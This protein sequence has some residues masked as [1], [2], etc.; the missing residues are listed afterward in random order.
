MKK[1]FWSAFAMSLIS[2]TSL[3]YS[4]T[5]AVD[6]FLGLESEIMPEIV[7][8]QNFTTPE[9]HD[10]GKWKVV[11]DKVAVD[12]P[13]PIKGQTHSLIPWSTLD[14]EDWLSLDT[15]LSEQ[16]F[17]KKT[18]NWKIRLRQ[19]N[20]Q[21]LT[22]K[23]LQCKGTCSVFRGSNEASVQHLSQIVEGDEIR[24][25]KDSVA[26]VYLMD[27]S[28]MRISPESSV[29]INEFN[30]SKNEFFILARLN[31]GHIFWHPRHKSEVVPVMEPE[32]DS[33]SLPLMVREAN[34]EYFER[35]IYKSQDD[36]LHLN[37]VMKFDETAISNQFKAINKLWNQ[38]NEI[39]TSVT[40]F[41]MVSP[42]STLVSKG[43]SFDY[44]YI[45]GG[46]GYFNKRSDDSSGELSLYLRGYTNP[47][48]ISISKTNWH[49]VDPSG[50]TYSSM[51]DAP[52]ILQI[53]DLLTKRIKTLE[54][55][56]EIWVEKFTLPLIQATKDPEK[57]ARDYGYTFW[58]EEI[59]Q[60]YNFLVE[61]TR[62]VETTNLRSLEN[63]LTR[64]ENN[65][66]FVNRDLTDDHYS[67]SLN[68]YLLGLKS[69][70]DKKKMRVKEMN[71][72]QYYVWIL[73][74]GKW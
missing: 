65:G 35:Q 33:V 15:W 44:L 47:E 13:K 7:G 25:L 58:G 2:I 22:G 27:G 66:E 30:M 19:A 32:T 59:E 67:A 43:V 56:R 31:K 3:G 51:D 12:L 6:D 53:T 57:L 55:A 52:G 16:K 28:L 20:L 9:L 29:S 8:E 64:L 48:V 49:E 23:I 5:E 26:W 73:R 14:P 10:E 1:L 71:N 63:L 72:L 69:R 61:Y 60:R 17:K 18:P 38:N 46:K 11:P 62:R 54:L 68:H 45:P 24:T 70:Y 36:N 40:K 39:L 4:Q 21:E 42:N 50:R 74:N 34:Q 41:M 37:E